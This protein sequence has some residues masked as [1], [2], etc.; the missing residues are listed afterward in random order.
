MN[1]DNQQGSTGRRDEKPLFWV[2]RKG[3][4]FALI[5]LHVAAVIAVL[6]ELVRPFPADVH[7]VE[8]AHIL[9]FPA[10]YAVYGFVACVI[11]VLIGRVLRR[12]VIRDEHYYRDKR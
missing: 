1:V 10:S 5:A 11:L 8:R 9:D 12:L 6:I 2:S 4:R 7:A 3:A